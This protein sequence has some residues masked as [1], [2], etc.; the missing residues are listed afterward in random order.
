MDLLCMCGNRTI[1]TE[2]ISLLWVSKKNKV[3]RKH[4]N[5]Y[6]ISGESKRADVWKLRRVPAF[7]TVN[8]G[9]LLMQKNYLPFGS[10]SLLTL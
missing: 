6:L 10:S 7:T 1:D 4:K 5:D 2:D 3:Y 8:V 9:F